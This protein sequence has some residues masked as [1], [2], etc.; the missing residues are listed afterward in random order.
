MQKWL[1][2]LTEDKQ[3]VK[4]S[5]V[6]L[7]TNLH[8]SIPHKSCKVKAAMGNNEQALCQL[9][10]PCKT[11]EGKWLRQPSDLAGKNIILRQKAPILPIKAL[12]EVKRKSF[13]QKQKKTLVHRGCS[14]A[15]FIAVFSLFVCVVHGCL[16]LSSIYGLLNNICLHF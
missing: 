8:R 13:G 14:Y 3:I 10:K 4:W 12:S 2:T 11:K 15:H 16:M 7:P 6:Q 5:S 9:S 1:L